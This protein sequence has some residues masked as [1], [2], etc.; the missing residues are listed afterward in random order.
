MPYD[1]IATYYDKINYDIDYIE[2]TDYLETL[3]LNYNNKSKH[4]LDFA[5]GTGTITHYL[6]KKGFVI[7]G[8]DESANMIRKAKSK[9]KDIDFFHTTI[10]NYSPERKYDVIISTFDSI[11]TI[12]NE[13]ILL[14]TFKKIFSLL[15]KNGIFIFDINTQYG[16]RALNDEFTYTK[17]YMNIF[18]VWKMNY[19][20]LSKIG[21]LHLT[22]FDKQSSNI[23]SRDDFILY[24]KVYSISKLK[25]YLKKAGFMNLDILDHLTMKSHL[26][27]SYRVDFVSVKQE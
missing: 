13:E 7:S 25:K 4:I 27:N 12:T 22:I 1:K 15:K 19:D 9:Y 11:N 26:R 5:C 3:I 20:K 8:I 10:F 6:H 16:F 14:E 17:E 18:S 21:K 2:W 24:E 23:Y